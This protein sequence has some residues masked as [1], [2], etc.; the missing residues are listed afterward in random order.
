[1]KNEEIKSIVISVIYNLFKE[2][3]YDIRVIEYSNLIDDMG[4][5][6]IT[7]IS[8]VVELEDVFGLTI[9]TELLLI[10]NFKTVDEIVDLIKSEF[11]KNNKIE[12]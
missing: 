1:M 8:L 10:E 2:N 4:M 12:G 11:E 3:G 6:S 5:D 7:F 9:S